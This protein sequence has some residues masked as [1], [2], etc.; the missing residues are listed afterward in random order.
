[1]DDSG[2]RGALS[3][4]S[5]MEH[6]DDTVIVHCGTVINSR[7]CPSGVLK[8]RPRPPPQLF[9]FL[10]S[11]ANDPIV[12]SGRYDVDGLLCARQPTLPHHLE[13]ERG[14]AFERRGVF[15]CEAAAT[16]RG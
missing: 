3:R 7:R 15:D 8:Y 16:A 12:R 14:R 5:R 4:R 11:L 9:S 10:S 13:G 1:M 6:T 2:S